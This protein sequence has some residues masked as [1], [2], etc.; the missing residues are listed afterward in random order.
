MAL[1]V[2][3]SQAE[4]ARGRVLIARFWPE[5][6]YSSGLQSRCY[7]KEFCP[8]VDDTKHVQVNQPDSNAKRSSADIFSGHFG[9][10]VR[11]HAFAVSACSDARR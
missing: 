3:H 8:E 2:Y 5:N 11:G 7:F 10:G 4:L 9:G 6:V 1:A